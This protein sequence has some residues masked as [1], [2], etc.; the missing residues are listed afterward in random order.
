[1]TQVTQ[2]AIAASLNTGP[3]TFVAPTILATSTGSISDSS[4]GTA[5][6]RTGDARA[7]GN[8]STT[9]LHQEANGD[10]DGFGLVVETQVA[11]VLN[12][13]VG[14]A[15]SG[16]NNATG[17]AAQ[18]NATAI[19]QVA[20]TASATVADPITVIAAGPIGASNQADVSHAS[21]GTAEIRTGATDA[22]GNV[23]SP[24]SPRS[25]GVGGRHG[26]GDPHSAG[27]GRERRSRVGQLG[28]EHGHRQRVDQQHRRLQTVGVLAGLMDPIAVVA[29]GPVL[30][31]SSFQGG[32]TSDGT[33]KV[34]TGRAQ[35]T[36][37]SSTP[38]CPRSSTAR[39]PTWAWWS[40]RRP[41]GPRRGAGPSQQRSEHRHRQHLPDTIPI[42][43]QTALVPGAPGPVSAIVVG[44]VIGSNT[45]SATNVSDGE[46]CVCTG[47]AIASGNIA[48]TELSQDLDANVGP[49]AV[50]LTRPAGSS[51][52]VRPTPTPARTRPSAT[53]PPTRST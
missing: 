21:D 38:A 43:L 3:A 34:G 14:T 31:S 39:S 9:D 45:L 28:R 44:P 23:S 53:T 42:G 37:N 35:S 4:D 30:G 33:A 12:A 46:A 13:G 7:I 2:Q 25:T 27:R 47:D 50:V 52:S 36:G 41:P 18:G 6:I 11:P 51:T 17:N 22:R 49:G 24:R 8:Q 48:D 5:S 29:A 20:S 16:S 40:T 1:M 15:T 32:N 26:R 10:V 19:A